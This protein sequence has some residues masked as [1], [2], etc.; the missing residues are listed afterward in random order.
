M[1]AGEATGRPRLAMSGKREVQVFPKGQHWLVETTF[2]DT[3]LVFETRNEAENVGRELAGV[4]AGELQIYNHPPGQSGG[5]VD[6]TE[7]PPGPS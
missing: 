6:P 1:R 3:H 2:D 4:E 7:V 5:G